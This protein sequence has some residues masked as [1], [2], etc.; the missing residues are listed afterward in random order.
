MP[1]EYH[2]HSLAARCALCGTHP[3]PTPSLLSRSHHPTGGC[4][5]LPSDAS[6]PAHWVLCKVGGTSPLQQKQKPDSAIAA[7]GKPRAPAAAFAKGAPVPR[8]I[9]LPPFVRTA[10]RE[11]VGSTTALFSVFGLRSLP[12]KR[13]HAPRPS[14][15]ATA[16]RLKSI[17]RSISQVSAL[18]CAPSPS[19]CARTRKTPRAAFPASLAATP[20]QGGWASMGGRVVWVARRRGRGGGRGGGHFWQHLQPSAENLWVW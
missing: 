1:P 11:P 7:G 6:S 20:L 16:A 2:P 18:V 14:R 19:L 15:A 13:R 10:D 17:G 8:G 4:H 9:A 5:T 12:R 3:E